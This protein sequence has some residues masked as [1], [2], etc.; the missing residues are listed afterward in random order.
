VEK[1]SESK[2]EI[3]MGQRSNKGKKGGKMRGNW[4][5]NNHHYHYPPSRQSGVGKGAGFL[6]SLKDSR[7]EWDRR[8]YVE[9]HKRK[10]QAWKRRFNQ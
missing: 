3:K 7:N 9:R 5:G 10:H 8:K 6:N 2:G 4:A 1:D